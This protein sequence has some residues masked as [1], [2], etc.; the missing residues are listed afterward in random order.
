MKARNPYIAGVALHDDRSFF[1]RQDTIARVATEL[2][3]QGTNAFVL[4]GQRRI[5]KTSLLLRLNR[6]LDEEA[7]LPV[8][9]DLQDHAAYP[10]GEVL[11]DMADALADKA[12]LELADPQAFDDEGRYFQKNFLRRLREALG[13]GKRP[14]L[15]LDEFDVLDQ[16]AEEELPPTVAAKA[17][18][19]FL[20]KLLT[21]NVHLA[22]VFA[23][24]R[25]SEDLT[26]NFRATFKGS[27]ALEV[28][29]LREEDAVGLIRQAEENGTLRFTDQ[30][31]RHILD[32]TS[33]HPYLM[34]LLCQ[35]IWYRAYGATERP[36]EP[37]LIDIAEVDAAIP[38][39]LEAGNEALNWLWDG[40][41]PH[42]KIY[43][44]AFAQVDDEGDTTISEDHVIRVITDYAA[45]LRTPE[46]EQAPQKLV[47]LR[48]LKKSGE[49]K[50]RFAVELFRRWVAQQKSLDEI[51]D[52][53]DRENQEANKVYDA[54]KEYFNSRKWEEAVRLFRQALAAN[55]NHFRA[56][57]ELG[58]SLLKLGERDE[59]VTELEKAYHLDRAVARLPLARA[60]IEQAKT[61]VHM[62]DEDG[63]LAAASRALEISPRE[64]EAQELKVSIWTK[65]GDTARAQGEAARKQGDTVR[66]E[67]D[68]EAALN[69]YLQ[70]NDTQKA[71]EIRPELT[72]LGLQNEAERASEGGAWGEAAKIYTRLLKEFA[73]D[74]RYA[75]WQEA[76]DR[77]TEEAGLARHFE[78]GQE[79]LQQGGWVEAQRE[80]AVI[81][82]QDPNYEQ[83]GE[84]A[85]SLSTQARLEHQGQEHKEAQRW[86]EA[87]TTYQTLLRLFPKNEARVPV[88]EE[89]LQAC[90]EGEALARLFAGGRESIRQ[91]NLQE[92]ERIF[93]DLVERSAEYEQNGRKAA[94]LLEE[95]R[96]KRKLRTTLEK[97]N[98]WEE[99]IAAYQQLLA[100]ATDEEEREAWRTE[101][102]RCQKELEVTQR[103]TEGI[104]YLNQ[105]EW[106]QA[107]RAFADVLYHRPN[108]QKEGQN[109][110]QLLQ[111]AL[112]EG[113]VKQAPSPGRPSRL[114][115][116]LAG[117]LFAAFLFS[118]FII[119]ARANPEIAAPI[120]AIE[121]TPPP[122]IVETVV[123]TRIENTGEGPTRVVTVIATPTVDEATP[124]SGA[125]S[126]EPLQVITKE[127]PAPITLEPIA[128]TPT[129]LSFGPPIWNNL[130]GIRPLE[131]AVG[132][133]QTFAAA[134]NPKGSMLAVATNQGIDIY[135][136][137]PGAAKWAQQ[138]TL[139]EMN[140]SV[141]RSVA[142]SETPNEL[143][144]LAAGMDNGDVFLWSI[145]KDNQVITES[146]KQISVEES[147][148]SQLA[149]SPDGLILATLNGNGRVQLW[150]VSS[151]NQKTFTA[152]GIGTVQ[153]M[154]FYP[155]PEDGDDEMTKLATISA[156]GQI[157]QWDAHFAY[158]G[159][160]CVDQTGSVGTRL[161]L[162][163]LSQAGKANDLAFSGDGALIATAFEEGIIRIWDA[164]S[165]KQ[166]TYF[167]AG[168]ASEGE[169]SEETTA[170]YSVDFRPGSSR[171][172]A[173]LVSGST[174]GIQVWQ[175]I[176]STHRPLDSIMS[177]SNGVN[178]VAFS[179][180]A[181][182][183]VSTSPGEG[184]QLWHAN[185]QPPGQLSGDV[186]DLA[187]FSTQQENGRFLATGF[188]NGAI[189]I[190]NLDNQQTYELPQTPSTLKSLHVYSGDDRTLLAA[191]AGNEVRV[192]QTP[193]GSSEFEFTGAVAADNTIKSV[194]LTSHNG[195]VYLATGGND[196]AIKLWELEPEDGF[197]ES[198]LQAN[199][200][201]IADVSSLAL[202]AANGRLILAA[203][204]DPNYS[205]RWWDLLE[206][207]RH[208][209]AGDITAER[210]ALSPD[211]RTA[212]VVSTDGTIQMWRSE[213]A[214]LFSQPG[215]PTSL[216]IGEATIADVEVAF[217][218]DDYLVAI[219]L[220]DGTMQLATAADTSPAPLEAYPESITG[221]ALAPD[222]AFIA[223]G[224]AT[225]NT[226]LWGLSQEE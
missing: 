51:K 122:T 152:N 28:W 73:H 170:V 45:R 212:V 53:L 65:R 169:N 150:C 123:I 159:E 166:L 158:N 40:L 190:Q 217:H 175:I 71:E 208:Q 216:N 37:P 75:V 35:R 79:Y 101:I 95:T 81:M 93:T 167:S 90:E 88:W 182:N 132:N 209:M 173:V 168:D 83:K 92:A 189:Q 103:F 18:F 120:L 55:E 112:T 52:E 221:I 21:E 11:A 7:F 151:Q 14:V 146:Q 121:L 215:T 180:D 134:Y 210:I 186:V 200:D 2:S 15:L 223:T 38:D 61:R 203:G 105:E 117:F 128:V 89:M 205:P 155:N 184:V 115:P 140:S 26:E 157:R 16:R 58:E 193:A 33:H 177:S 226:K 171:Q 19:P 207:S 59:A 8:Y 6:T 118:S 131:N 72:I 194:A 181:L 143:I 138:G 156:D 87:I 48:I 187:T 162:P 188:S 211:G 66:A 111:E 129:A 24:G 34:Q 161:S 80:F 225:G 220:S 9:V 145:D 119:T 64:R 36:A 198:S 149:F 100:Q 54:G 164:E 47:E 163:S 104:G 98:K 202:S 154:A 31:V 204:F 195:T 50:Y 199:L 63:A 29:A 17:F 5:G 27:T 160:N 30:A 141:A 62:G 222:G 124:G 78:R 1:G 126:A 77:S 107:Q 172:D 46:V 85:A 67:R 106:S 69:A 3:N 41:S 214:N 108:Y 113:E 179:P 74:K 196:A 114:W 192:W 136:R 191:V 76:L 12:G 224:T 20:R 56:R 165:L 185:V 99:A 10:L 183:I 82:Q 130:D 133:R 197:V 70:A 97:E 174:E 60:L 137:Q 96:Q 127:V 86:Q 148:V 25:R 44:A 219:G 22:F 43:A 116:L 49:N 68:F 147:G 213:G 13:D 125:G 142:F 135:T 4:F 94:D 153:S 39:A 201:I 218:S 42:E 23:V 84:T 102:E 91:N 144:M 57:L 178:D 139:A 206:P 32:L 176:S 109:A 110:N